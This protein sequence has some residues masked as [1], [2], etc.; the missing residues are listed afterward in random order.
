M[1]QEVEERNPNIEDTEDRSGR[2]QTVWLNTQTEQERLG[3]PQLAWMGYLKVSPRLHGA[4]GVNLSDSR[5][6]F[7][8]QCLHW[9]K[10]PR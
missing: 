9:K 3:H 6:T 10:G 2:V 4:G 7:P 8:N 5:V 1:E